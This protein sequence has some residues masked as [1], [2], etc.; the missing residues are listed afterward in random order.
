MAQTYDCKRDGC[1]FDSHSGKLMVIYLYFHFFALV[2]RP[3]GFVTKA[4]K[5]HLRHRVLKLNTQCLENSAES[6]E[7]SVLTLNTRLTLSTLL[8]AGYNMK[9]KKNEEY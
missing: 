2:T 6:R 8:F 9:M 5:L 4:K 1:R 7:Q 3:L